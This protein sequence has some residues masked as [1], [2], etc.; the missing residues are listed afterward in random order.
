VSIANDLKT[1]EPGQINVQVKFT[2]SLTRK[3]VEASA[4]MNLL[5]F[6]Y[7]IILTGSDTLVSNQPYNIKVSARKIGTGTP[8]SS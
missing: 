8:V 3:V 1:S 5:Q 4:I 2:E 6:A 7:E